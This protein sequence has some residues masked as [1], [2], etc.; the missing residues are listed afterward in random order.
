MLFRDI[1][2]TLLAWKDSPGR[3]PLL[4]RGARQ[5][6]KSTSVRFFGAR[7]FERC[8]VVNFEQ[9]SE[10]KGC[11]DTLVP[12]EIVSALSLVSGERIRA[13]ETLLFLDEIQE[14]PR[15]LTALR[16]FYEQ[17]P[18]LAVVAA[19]SLIEFTIEPER[20]RIPVGRVGFLYMTPLSFCEFLRSSG[21][22]VL[23]DG[24]AELGLGSPLPGP[25]HD[26]LLAAVR[27]YGLLGGMPAV[28]ARH[29]ETGD[30]I[31]CQHAQAAI[32]Q[33]YRESLA[34]YASRAQQLHM[35]SLFA[36]IPRLVGRKFKYVAVD[37]TVP[38][39]TLKPA[40]DLL[41]K[42]GV[43]V[44]VRRTTGA[45]LPLAA[46]TSATFFKTL[47]LDVGLMQRGC[48]LDLTVS[49][50]VDLLAAH[51][52]AVAEQLVGQEL[53]ACRDPHAPPELYYWAREKRGSSAEVDYLFPYGG[54]IFPVEV[55]AGHTGRLKSLHMF[56]DRY[57][58]PFGIRMSQAPLSFGNRVLS[59]PIYAVSR[60]PDLIEETLA[61]PS[62]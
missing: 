38:S 25:A 58:A 59:V 62:M 47:F 60:L 5:V 39:R 11:F 57:G 55:K 28:L 40:L 44:R 54:Q 29:L 6:G 50:A 36:A 31:A 4:V 46:G 3:M 12:S 37:P 56:L 8:V 26:R 42:A 10:F 21:G 45:G 24:L 13:P 61:Q 27:R 23:V 43:A 34:K 32:V 35:E 22:D 53:L 33:S 41:V 20:F 14:C 18:D 17:M 9:Y 7:H 2:R 49:R 15:A 16:Y 51:A 1:D 30:M 48:G 52:G 19:G